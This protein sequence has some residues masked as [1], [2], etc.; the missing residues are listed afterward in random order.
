MMETATSKLELTLALVGKR[1]IEPAHLA[2]MK[3]DLASVFDTVSEALAIA[4]GAG[5]ARLTLITG[6]ADGADQIASAIFLHGASGFVTRVL[7]AILPCPGE[8]FAR[9]SPV[10]RFGGVRA[11]GPELLVHHRTARALAA[12]AA[13]RPDHRRRADLPGASAVT[14]SRLK[15]TPC[16]GT[17]TSSWRSTIPMMRARSA[18]RAIPYT[19]RLAVGCP[20][21]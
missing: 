13:R 12:A 5:G 21:S 7:G 15:P 10:E 4:F 14:P 2:A 20:S 8:E 19:A 11:G 1:R 17:P 6:L 18:A 3:T 16:Y 9:N